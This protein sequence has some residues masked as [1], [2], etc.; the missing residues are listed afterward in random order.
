MG[1]TLCSDTERGLLVGG[2]LTGKCPWDLVVREL[3]VEPAVAHGSK[4]SKSIFGCMK[5][6]TGVAEALVH[7]IQFLLDHI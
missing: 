2:Q 3:G 4:G 7:F 6:A 1:K 5:R